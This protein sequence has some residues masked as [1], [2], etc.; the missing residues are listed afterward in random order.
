MATRR[1][2]L[3]VAGAATA[4]TLLDP[5]S[6][7]T[8][9]SGIRIGY[10]AITWQGDDATAIREVSEL[11]FPGIQLRSPI[12]KEYGDK[13]AALKALLNQ[14][15]LVMVALSSGGVRIDPAVEKEEFE[16]H[17]EAR[18]FRAGRRWAVSA[19]DGLA[20]EARAHAR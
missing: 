20:S 1:E 5:R 7:L 16:L 14:H 10:A 8:A 13:P 15:K 11:G 19:G 12:L 9:A 17:T 6:A 18:P 2:F 3:E 4:A